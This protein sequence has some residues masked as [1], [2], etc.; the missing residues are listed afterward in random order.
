VA[1]NEPIVV[2]APA[3][4]S[5][6]APGTTVGANT[7]WRQ[8]PKAGYIPS[9]SFV[10]VVLLTGVEAGTAT[11]SESNPQPVLMRLERRAI[12]PGAARY[13]VASCFAL[14]SAYGS[15]STERAYVRLARISC[16]DKQHKLVL[17]SPIKGYLAD[18]DGMFGLRGKLVERRGALLAK[19]LLSGFISGLGSALGSAQGVATT[20]AFGAQSA[21][22]GTGALKA[23]GFQGGSTAANQLAQFYL[24][25]AQAIFPVVEVPPRRK[26]TLVI[27]EGA[28]LKWTQYGTLYLRQTTPEK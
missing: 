9:G 2:T 19:T 3:A 21:F 15:M 14:G 5:S 24:K 25:Q 4:A 28:D 1:S 22:S 26:G 10:P 6:V 8:N 12:L 18:S 23:A 27:T 17:D 20:G 7:S 16:V 11:T 13:A